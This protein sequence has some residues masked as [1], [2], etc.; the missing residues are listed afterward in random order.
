MDALLDRLWELANEDDDPHSARRS[1][2]VTEARALWRA[3]EVLLTS[4]R[5]Q[6]LAVGDGT[7]TKTLAC[8][9]SV[10]SDS[11]Y[12]TVSPS[13]DSASGSTS[14]DSFMTVFVCVNRVL[15]KVGGLGEQEREALVRDGVADLIVR[16][17]ESPQPTSTLSA[18]EAAAAL[19]TLQSLA[20]DSKNRPSLQVSHTIRLCIA[21]MQKHET[22][23]AVQLRACQFLHQMTFEEDCKERIGRHGG[24]QA[25]TSALSRFAKEA[26]LAVTA[27]D[28][29][30][31]LCVDLEY[32][33]D[34]VHSVSFRSAN[35]TVFRGVVAAVV[36][37][38]RVLQGVEL[39]QANGVAV[40]NS[41]AMH[42]PVRQS[43]GSLDIWDIAENGLSTTAA[44]E[45]ACD[46]VELLDA[47]L[48]DPI[49]FET[50]RQ[51]LCGTAS[52]PQHQG[53]TKL[54]LKALK[55]QV[56]A[57]LHSQV[58]SEESSAR[59][60]FVASQLESL[61]DD[62]SC[63]VA[64]NPSS[65]QKDQLVC[66]DG[67]SID[68]D[69]YG[70]F[71][72]SNTR[73]AV[74]SHASTHSDDDS[75]DELPVAAAASLG[76]V[77][78]SRGDD[79]TGLIVVGEHTGYFE[80]FLQQT[81]GTGASTVSSPVGYLP[82]TVAEL[83]IM[84]QPGTLC[85]IPSGA[86]ICAKVHS[87]SSIQPRMRKQDPDPIAVNSCRA[88]FN[89]DA[90]KRQVVCSANKHE[91]ER[92][93]TDRQQ[94][95]SD[96]EAGKWQALYEASTREVQRVQHSFHELTERYHIVLRRLKE[97]TKL[98]ALQNARI[99][100]NGNEH[101]QILRRMR[102]LETSLE[103][104]DRRCQV[105]RALRSAEA[106]QCEH[107]SLA[108]NDSV[109][110]AKS[111]AAQQSSAARELQQ[112]ESMRTEYM[113]RTRESKQD[114]QRV[115][116]ERDNALIHIQI[117]KQ[118]KIDVLQQLADCRRA[119]HEALL[120]REEDVDARRPGVFSELAKTAA[121]PKG[122][123]QTGDFATRNASTSARRNSLPTETLAAHLLESTNVIPLSSSRYRS[124]SVYSVQTHTS[125]VDEGL[126][127]DPDSIDTSEIQSSLVSVFESLDTSIEGSNDE[128][129]HVS[130]VR[131]FFMESGL[132][133]A[134][135][136]L[137]ADVD[138]VLAG[139]LAQAQSNRKNSLV[140]KDFNGASQQA[141]APPTGWAKTKKRL[142]PTKSASFVGDAKRF[143][144]F[145][146]DAFNEA[147]T[148]V[149]MRKFPR[150]DLLRVLQTVVALYLRPYMRQRQSLRL[151]STN[152]RSRSSSMCSISR[153]SST[154]VG[155]PSQV[156]SRALKTI[157][158]GLALHLGHGNGNEHLRTS[159]ST[160]INEGQV[161]S[162]LHPPSSMN[163]AHK[164]EDVV[165]SMLEMA[166]VL[167]RE[168]R[169]LGTIC[170]FYSA[171]HLPNA[172]AAAAIS[173]TKNELFGL[174]FELMLSFA[175]DFGLIPSFMDRV[176]L[177][178]LHTEVSSLLKAYFA[179]HD[180]D[181]PTGADAETLKKVA[182]GMVLA[183]LALELFSTKPG[184]ET[185][186]CQI[187]GLL[188]WLDNSPGR[189]KIMRKAGIPL[190]IRFSRQLYSV[191]A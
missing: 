88:T 124:S 131:R 109:R 22:V 78:D 96:K 76:Y 12:W 83:D 176:S 158:T 66:A 9:R 10:L 86:K 80:K 46:F 32:R 68:Y 73:S 190:V 185:P 64:S 148:L 24:L 134:P 136:V 79:A 42:S 57:L 8:V 48:R 29:L 179:L 2:R 127:D 35:A 169:P 170:E 172:A 114:K 119:G 164:R 120:M 33:T 157:L 44:D 140:R 69:G 113:M 137:P 153:R 130:T 165:Y 135:N 77:N 55:G 189:E 121:A 102:T 122:A 182:F 14:D 84:D 19:Q 104:A 105:E 117:L 177:K 126:N 6:E 155:S 156:C 112:N 52:A 50:M 82:G 26:E 103:E 167:N 171:Q 70:Q 56:D 28:V 94:S 142:S 71:V 20:T 101:Q 67:N 168:Q 18:F 60:V 100:N 178:H 161:H 91:A 58:A 65:L 107:L 7:F 23:F 188:Q 129:V 85:K 53:I 47:L 41:M 30:F 147:V 184:Y 5:P 36:D 132:V 11:S 173:I 90:E 92:I 111:L 191:K 25:V 21:L 62:D 39:V 150:S 141:W 166:G 81:H 133:Q 149:G 115:E 159:R 152:Q 138:V 72:Y 38:M 186:E 93:Q 59:V 17:G 16:C 139:V 74:P 180:K 15:L 143:R 123:H 106:V 27:L 99:T 174:S 51:K 37:V 95:T 1:E 187:T 63:D 3:L 116:F 4:L 31:F 43:L 87:I 45:A 98:L 61:L 118:E 183:R 128:G 13:G 97:Q 49:T 160:D 125:G 40:L 163:R 144:F 108:L 75:G 34:P 154:S 89:G 145:N 175:T 162:H 110:E 181:L 151:S 54:S 146:Q